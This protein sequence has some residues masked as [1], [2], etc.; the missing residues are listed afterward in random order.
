M[1]DRFSKALWEL[2]QDNPDLQEAIAKSITGEKEKGYSIPTK[3]F[4]YEHPADQLPTGQDIH[5]TVFTMEDP[6]QREYTIEDIK[7]IDQYTIKEV[8]QHLARWTSYLTLQEAEGR[9]L[10]PI[11]RTL[12][13]IDITSLAIL[14]VLA[15]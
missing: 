10:S 11:E 5:T 4:V 1:E 9:D 8:A 7:K 2:G 15:V 14:A 6:K 3:Q 12:K 13:D